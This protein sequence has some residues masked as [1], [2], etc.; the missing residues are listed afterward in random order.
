MGVCCCLLMQDVLLIYVTSNGL[1]KVLFPS[2]GIE[3]QIFG[4]QGFWDLMF[5][6]S[7]QNLL[8]ACK[9]AKFDTSTFSQGFIFISCLFLALFAVGTN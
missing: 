6:V 1:E 2:Q 9:G 4:Y 5:T 7:F 8:Y 3:A